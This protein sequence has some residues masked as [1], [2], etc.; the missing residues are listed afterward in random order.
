M[1]MQPGDLWCLDTSYVHS[2][3]NGGTETRVHIIVEC[4][5]NPSIRARMPNS[6]KTKMHS[7]AY[8]SILGGSLAKSF[9]VNAF[10]DPA[11]FKA[12]MG[13]I[14]RFVG[15]RFFGTKKIG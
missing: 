5:I 3:N 4:N 1:R 2:V 15:W 7:A 6:L 12:Q 8:V 10:R 14:R 11:Y 13:M 9:L